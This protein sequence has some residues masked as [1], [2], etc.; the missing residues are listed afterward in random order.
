MLNHRHTVAV[1]VI[2]SALTSV[3]SLADVLQMDVQQDVMTSGFFQ[4]PNTVRGYASDGRATHR[5]STPGAFGVAGAETVYLTFDPADFAGITEPVDSAYL[6]VTS[7]SGGF[8]ADASAANPFTVSAHALSAD[9]LASIVDD[10]N[11]AGT[12]DWVTFY[13]DNILAADAEALTVVDG[14][15]QV[16]FDITSVVNGWV[17]GSNTVFAVALTGNNDT[18]GGDFLHG[19]VNNTEAPGSSFLTVTTVPEPG[20]L[21]LLAAG[22]VLLGRRRR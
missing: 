3:P 5:V 4:G 6:T 21:A 19:F 9:P 1:G 15:G 2:A 8:G 16:Q 12:T 14:F 18:S 11:P 13:N 17:A 20:S 7:I 10:T 22:G